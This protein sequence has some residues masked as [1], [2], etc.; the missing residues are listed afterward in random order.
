M[1][2]GNAFLVLGLGLDVIDGVGGLDLESDGLAG[3]SLNKDLHAGMWKKVCRG[4][5]GC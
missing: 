2:R 3:E 1:V 5:G 4:S